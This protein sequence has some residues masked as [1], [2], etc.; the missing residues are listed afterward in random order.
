MLALSLLTGPC[1]VFH[2]MRGC[3]PVHRVGTWQEGI[4]ASERVTSNHQLEGF[5]CI[6]VE[7]LLYFLY[8]FYFIC[9]QHNFVLTNMISSF[10]LSD[11]CCSSFPHVL[12]EHHR[13][14]ACPLQ[15]FLWK[16]TYTLLTCSQYPFVLPNTS[17]AEWD[18]W[19][20]FFSYPLFQFSLSPF[21]FFLKSGKIILV[22]T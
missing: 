10:S 21:N 2:N 5:F 13:P 4:L 3:L 16:G 9:L 22:L 14:L 18:V 20:Y 7:K 17:A 12:Q 1:Y 19:G 6:M 8:Y 11:L 15:S